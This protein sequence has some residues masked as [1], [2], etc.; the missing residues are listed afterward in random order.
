MYCFIFLDNFIRGK[1]RIYGIPTLKLDFFFFLMLP[2]LAQGSVVKGD[3]TGL[4]AGRVA[5]E[6]WC[7]SHKGHC[8][9]HGQGDAGSPLRLWWEEP[10]TDTGRR[11]TW[12]H[13]VHPERDLIVFLEVITH[14]NN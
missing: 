4:P 13:R 11:W 3:G 14:C 12:K 1:S 6:A 9:G 10:Q 2:C 7:G 5:G 8:Q